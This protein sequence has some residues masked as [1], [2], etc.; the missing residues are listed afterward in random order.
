[1]WQRLR[2]GRRDATSNL[3]LALLNAVDDG[4]EGGWYYFWDTLAGVVAARPDVA[5]S[6]GARVEVETK[7]I[8]TLGQIKIVQNGGAN[9]RVGEEINRQKFEDD[10]LKV[11]LD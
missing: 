7:N 5:G 10:Y 1:M 3:L 11:V 2:E 9:V 8:S 4:I 6:Y